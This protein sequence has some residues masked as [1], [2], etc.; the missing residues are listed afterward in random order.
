MNSWESLAPSPIYSGNNGGAAQLNGKIY[1]SYTTA[2]GQ[3]G[4]YDIASNLWNTLSAPIQG[5]GLIE[6]DGAS[7]VY[8][9]S[10][11]AL[12]RF[13]PAT[14]VWTTLA[15]A[16]IFFS[17]WGGLRHA[18]G[19]LYGHV[20]NG[21]DAFASYDIPTDTWTVLPPIPA[22]AVMGAAFDP[23]V[24]EY[25]CYGT[26]GGSNLYRYSV[27]LGTWSVSSIPFFSVFDG[28][29]AFLSAPIPAIYLVEGEF[30]TGFARAIDEVAFISTSDSSGTIPPFGHQDVDVRF[31]SGDLF[32]GTYHAQIGIASND[33]VTPVLEV[34]A[35][36]RVIGSPNIVLE[37]QAVA[38]SSIVNYSTDGART[39]HDLPG[40]PVL[41][42]SA[43]IR[44][45]VDGDFGDFSEVAT[46]SIEGSELA[47]VGRNGFDCT[48]TQRTVVVSPAQLQAWSAD[49]HVQAEI[50]NT[51][52][53]N[54]FCGINRH[55]LVLTYQ[56]P[57]TAIDYGELFIGATKTIAVTIRNRG[58]LALVVG[59]I[60]SSRPEFSTPQASF[61]VPPR[62]SRPLEIAYHPTSAGATTATLTIPSNDPDE[63]SRVIT[64]SGTG[65]VPPVASLDVSSIV[66]NLY[67]GGTSSRTIEVRNTGGSDLEWS[68]AL[69]TAALSQ[70]ESVSP[71]FDRDRSS[72][73]TKPVAAVRSATPV[74]PD[75]ASLFA[76]PV[77]AERAPA[78][79]APRGATSLETPSSGTSPGIL[80]D[81]ALES[82][83]AAL[84]SSYIAVT[85]QIPFRFDFLDGV[86]GSYI[87]DGGNDMYD[88]G[89]FL[90]TNLGGALPYS[91]GTILSNSI[92][93]PTG[94][95]FTRKYPGLF[96]LAADLDGVTEFTID[97]NLGADGGGAVDGAVLTASLQ[98][99]Q[100]RAFSKRVYD[101]GD[102][103]VNHLI[104]VADGPGLAHDFTT[105]TDSDFHRARGLASTR[106]IYYLLYSRE[107][108]GHISD[109]QTIAILNAF[110]GA[111]RV[112]PPWLSA[113]PQTGTTIAGGTT[114]VTLGFDATDLEA[115]DYFGN[116][117]VSSNDPIHSEITL[118]V[119]LH[120][121]GRPVLALN[122]SELDLGNVFIGY[123][124]ARQV[125]AINLGSEPLVV[126]GMSSDRPDFS[127]SPSAFTLAPHESTI[128]TVT[129]S[130][131][132]AGQQNAS[133]TIASN[134][135][136]SP[137]TLSLIG[138]GV[139]P[140][141]LSLDQTAIEKTAPPGGSRTATLHICNT[142]GS[143]LSFDGRLIEVDT[144]PE[145]PALGASSNGPASAMSPL[146]VR[147]QGAIDPLYVPGTRARDRSRRAS[148][149]PAGRMPLATAGSTAMPRA[150]RC[151]S[152]SIFAASEPRSA[153]GAAPMI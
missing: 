61:T 67:P 92:L 142:G 78:A 3:I 32:D 90:T 73:A 144:A 48:A 135:P 50:Q 64:L 97:G 18:Q 116:L 31:E 115:G 130:P 54:P 12:Q 108:G 112:S 102:P 143:P 114:N 91:D 7:Y 107:F 109:P 63:P 129:F 19:K 21:S 123:S 105:N 100:Y 134:D 13:H 79:G 87:E 24:N 60:T 80:A 81:A 42:T 131:H 150:A 69:E 11:G 106:R 4:V 52:D 25:V 104:V 110:L 28:G 138:N 26:Y 44:F 74:I 77:S 148:T 51:I 93:G 151:I 9:V 145:A 88:N 43:T 29:L 59:P 38:E 36:L 153:S 127:A 132:S 41:A 139:P 65:L 94:R 152:G 124:G 103:S 53:V 16:P 68:I 76:S 122:A 125:E 1:T 84:D 83:L 133:L 98:G 33:P 57:P 5:T 10:G 56:L 111:I 22:G 46:L 86:T 72:T 58:S 49:G 39:L 121:V 126:S 85:G 137:E 140:P 8:V 37:G 55:T 119:Q 118:P 82:V 149:R 23:M 62:S 35:T 15:S 141:H 66:E 147:Q 136:E 47:T 40:A 75:A 17:P 146:S 101:S 89:N 20:G 128:V 120:V 45:E 113:A 27:S 95:Y 70:V 2:S 96:V 117:L 99:S 6:S 34:P 14:Q 71:R 30:G